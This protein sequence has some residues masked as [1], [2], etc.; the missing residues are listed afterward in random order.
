[1]NKNIDK[2]VVLYSLTRFFICIFILYLF[3]NYGHSTITSPELKPV[4][5]GLAIVVLYAICI[6]LLDLTF[7]ESL[8]VTS[9]FIIIIL[10]VFATFIVVRWSIVFPACTMML[11]CL[12]EFYFIKWS[13]DDCKQKQKETETSNDEIKDTENIEG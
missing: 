7:S 8:D 5:A 6:F 4:P 10:D 12:L 11:F 13:N 9:Q 1:M 2:N 3:I